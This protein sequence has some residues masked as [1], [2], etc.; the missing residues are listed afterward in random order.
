MAIP[1]V[2]R[3]DG[4]IK[5]S[6][7]QMASHPGTRH[8]APAEKPLV[9]VGVSQA[10][11][12]QKSAGTSRSSARPRSKRMVPIEGCV[13]E[14]GEPPCPR[15]TKRRRI[16]SAAAR[17]HRP[18]M[19]VLYC[20]ED[21]ERKLEQMPSE[22]CAA[23]LADNTLILR[24]WW[25]LP[26]KLRDGRRSERAIRAALARVLKVIAGGSFSEREGEKDGLAGA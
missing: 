21:G 12:S 23:I 2:D 3:D 24:F 8:C 22:F 7:R 14:V 6:R 5:C 16:R 19:F 18:S 25:G 17:F 11:G 10:R 15:V 13:C 20:S 4:W 1:R 26:Q 9:N